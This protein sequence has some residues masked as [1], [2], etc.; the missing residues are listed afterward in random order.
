MNTVPSHNTLIADIDKYLEKTGMKA[1]KFGLKYLNDSGAV[2]RIRSG[3]N[4]R[5]STVQ[6]IYEIIG[7]ENEDHDNK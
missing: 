1:H 6:K 3:N 2:F 7:K 4:P 5:L